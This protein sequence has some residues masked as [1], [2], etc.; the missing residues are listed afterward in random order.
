MARKALGRGLASLIPAAVNREVAVAP[1]LRTVEARQG[2]IQHV[3]LDKIIRYEQRQYYANPG[4]CYAEGWALN[5]FFQKSEVAKK[6]GYFAIPR[7]MLQELKATG[8]WEKAT[9][10][11]FAGVDLKKM[12][13]EWKE[14]VLSLPAPKDNK[15]G[16]ENP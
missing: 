13:E 14:F 7:Q 16:A 3:A 5:Y 11:V 1:E 4:L 10:K 6:K 8:N 9:D 12:E 2:E 15:A